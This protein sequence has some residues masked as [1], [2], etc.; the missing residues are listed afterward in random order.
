MRDG[1]VDGCA[2]N[3]RVVE[4]DERTLRLAVDPDAPLNAPA[5]KH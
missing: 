3:L 4:P 5:K 2:T 1:N